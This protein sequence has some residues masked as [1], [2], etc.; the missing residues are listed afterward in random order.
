M[1]KATLRSLLARR[2]R[3]GQTVLS[4]ALG[5]AFLA[6][7]LVLADTADQAFA[8]LFRSARAGTDLTVF[9]S[10][11]QA[12]GRH[13]PQPEGLV[14][15]VREVP[16]VAAAEGRVFGNAQ[17]V[18]KAGE[19]I[20]P[21]GASTFSASYPADHGLASGYTIRRG[22]PP[23]QSGE[24]MIDAATAERDGFGIGD[25]IRVVGE[26]PAQSFRIVGITGFGPADSPAGAPLALF[27]L[28]TAQQ[29]FDRVG[30]IDQVDVRAAADVSGTRLRAQLMGALPEDVVVL[31]SASVAADSARQA[32][33]RLDSFQAFLLAFAG[34]ALFVGAFIIWNTF[35]ILVAQRTRE[36]ALL[37][38]FGATRRQVLG[39]V[40]LEGAVVGLVGSITGLGLGLAAAVAFRQLLG[41]FDL[42]VPPSGLVVLP[43]TVVVALLTGTAVTI[44][45][46]LS[47]ARRATRVL[48]L[49]ALRDADTP[50]SRFSRPR[51]VGGV[52]LLTLAAGMGLAGWRD[53]SSAEG[54]SLIAIGAV[55]ALLALT[56][57]GPLVARPVARAVGAPIARLPGITGKLARENAMRNPRRTTSTAA[58][59]MIGLSL[60][61]SASVLAASTK[62]LIADAVDH[63]SRADFYLQPRGQSEGVPPD[64]VRELA[65]QP[66]VAAVTEVRSGDAVINGAGQTVAAIDPVAAEH[67]VDLDIRAGSL[68]ALARDDRLLVHTA[69]ARQQGWHVGS[70][71]SIA[72]PGRGA[73]PFAIV[74]TFADKRLFGSDYVVS[75]QTY[76]RHFDIQSNDVVMVRAA[77]DTDPAALAPVIRRVVK[78]YPNVQV[79]DTS[80]FK[81]RLSDVVDQM[82]GV[83]TALLVLT[84]VVALLGIINTLALSVAERTREI[85]LLRAVGM[86]PRQ[87]RTMVRWESVI[88]AVLGGLVG[89][90][91]GIGL[92]AALVGVVAGE[93]GGPMTIEVPAVQLAA[94]LLLAGPAGVLAAAGP[95]RRA[96]R[97]NLL[98]AI[99]AE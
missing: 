74:G 65:D 93:T 3:L 50:A 17:L 75:L 70:A 83:V 73:R 78:P 21:G 5:I 35:S 62:R 12:D 20:E 28:A 52:A 31:P 92:G 72:F 63:S 44:V 86:L 43:E 59:L 36:I 66:D 80:S 98:A 67:L 15:S 40:L 55:A 10:V 34:V 90:V 32:Q 48:P 25:T 11:T 51:L 71:V 97:M 53:R 99:D 84:I 45:A 4:I 18:D 96:T 42:V 41:V 69:V 1:L 61:T 91:V 64:V 82:L 19:L 26:G 13:E 58:A 47:P 88:V 60:V 8:T 79:D 76:D 2:L 94:Y 27:D 68:A 49:Q 56:L 39:S 7:T 57:L 16:G 81:R 85:G 6:G 22:R 38:L 54:G 23:E 87:V 95:A 14:D 77:P 30:E 24:V 33:D 29:L 37:R 89:V 46:V 9:S